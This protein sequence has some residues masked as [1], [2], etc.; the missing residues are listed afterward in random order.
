METCLTKKFLECLPCDLKQDNLFIVPRVNTRGGLALFQRNDIV[1]DVM[2]LSL[3]QIDVVL[4]PRVD[5]AQGFTGFYKALKTSNQNTQVTVKHLCLNIDLPWIY[6]GDF[7][8]I[9]HSEEKL[10]GAHRRE[11]QMTNFR[12][13]LGSYSFRDLGYVGSLF[14]WCNNQFEGKVIWCHLDKV[15]ATPDWFMKFPTIQVHDIDGSLSDHSPLQVYLDDEN[16]RFHEK[17]RLFLI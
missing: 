14:T 3:N 7:N 13:A 11:R 4:N 16:I 1:L 2:N 9:F 8:E 6:V 17:W 12:D 10:G 5:D 15:M